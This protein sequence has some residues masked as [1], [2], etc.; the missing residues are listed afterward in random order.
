MLKSARLSS[1]HQ[2]KSTAEN[3]MSNVRKPMTAIA[4]C[5]RQID[6]LE[7]QVN[8]LALSTDK[9]RNFSAQPPSSKDAVSLLDFT[10]SS[11]SDSNLRIPRTI[12]TPNRVRDLLKAT[13]KAEFP[14]EC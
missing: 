5:F 7:R 10:M 4:A 12:P 6:S 3:A 1:P 2:A 8:N 9:S 13:V 14:P 11:S